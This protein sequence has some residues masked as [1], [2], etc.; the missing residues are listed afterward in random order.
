MD[1]FQPSSTNQKNE[2][3]SNEMIRAKEKAEIMLQFINTAY[4]RFDYQYETAWKVRLSI[5]TAFGVTTGFVL[6][7]DKW[8]PSLLEC[9]IGIVLI[10]AVVT[11][12]VFFWGPWMHRRAARFVR[13]ARFW[14]SKTENLIG[15]RLP[16]HLHPQNWHGTGGWS[17]G[18]KLG[19]W[20]AQPT[21]LSQ[22][23]VTVLFG[24]LVIMALVSRVG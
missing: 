7:S 21:Y 20:Y 13:V 22:A 5:W 10:L 19:P 24:L 6:T 9:C 2:H 14:E 4:R 17:R 12:V 3:G 11:V 16:E 23:L 8:K 18:Q 15:V 1:S